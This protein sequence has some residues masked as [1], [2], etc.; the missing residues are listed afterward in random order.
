MVAIWVLRGCPRGPVSEAD[1][2]HAPPLAESARTT[3]CRE[4]DEKRDGDDLA[5]DLLD[6]RGGRRSGAA[7][8]EQVVDDEHAFAR[9]DRVR[10]DLEHALAVLQ[11][12]PDRHGLAGQLAQLAHRDKAGTEKIGDRAAEDEA[13][14]LDTGD[15]VDLLVTVRLDQ[16]IDGCVEGCAVAE[17]RSD[18]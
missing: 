2:G 10:L 12:V 8:G 6:E 11:P 16:T 4:L 9:L 3:Q 18:V 5:A 7:R 15:L 17:Q 1:E 13:A 14:G